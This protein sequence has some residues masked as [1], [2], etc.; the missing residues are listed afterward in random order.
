MEF[1]TYIR[2][3]TLHCK[4]KEDT[5]QDKDYILPHITEAQ[6]ISIAEL[7]QEGGRKRVRHTKSDQCHRLQFVYREFEN[8][9]ELS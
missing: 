1:H 5:S 4:V 7:S 9:E 3:L 8:R 2:L 6:Q